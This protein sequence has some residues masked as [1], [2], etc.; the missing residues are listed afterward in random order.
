[1]AGQ[2]QQQMQQ[3]V[4]T[5][6]NRSSSSSSST[7][8]SAPS[9]RPEIA[10]IIPLFDLVQGH[11]PYDD[12]PEQLTSAL[13]DYFVAAA[14]KVKQSNCECCSSCGCDVAGRPPLL[15]PAFYRS[16]QEDLMQGVAV[17]HLA[18]E[19]SADVQ[20]RCRLAVVAVL[21][22]IT[23]AA[24]IDDVTQ[25]LLRYIGQQEL[26]IAARVAAHAGC[27]RII[28]QQRVI[29]Q[30]GKPLEQC[31]NEDLAQLLP[32]FRDTLTEVRKCMGSST[33]DE[34]AVTTDQA[35]ICSTAAALLRA[36]G[37]TAD[38]AAAPAAAAVATAAAVA[39]PTGDASAVPAAAAATAS[40]S[41]SGSSSSSGWRSLSALSGLFKGITSRKVSSA[42]GA[43]DAA[44]GPPG[45]GGRDAAARGSIYALAA[46]AGASGVGDAEPGGLQALASA[47]DSDAES[48]DDAFEQEVKQKFWSPASADY[49]KEQEATTGELDCICRLAL[50]ND[51]NNEGWNALHYAAAT[52]KLGANP[53]GAEGTFGLQPLHLAC[54]GRVKDAA[55][56]D[57][58][59]DACGDIYSLQ[60]YAVMAGPACRPLVQLLLSK[61]V[62]PTSAVDCLFDELAGITPLHLLACWRHATSAVLSGGPAALLRAVAAQHVGAVRDLLQA[63]GA[64]GDSADVA[65]RTTCCKE[66]PLTFAAF[67]GSW[68]V[69]ELLLQA[70]ASP[71]LPRL[72]DAARPLDLAVALLHTRLACLLL[73]RGVEVGMGRRRQCKQQQQQ[74]LGLACLLLERG[75]EVRAR[76]CGAAGRLAPAAGAKSMRAHVIPSEAQ[77]AWVGMAPQPTP[78]RMQSNM[79]LLKSVECSAAP[80]NARL[81]ELLLQHGV[82]LEEVNRRGETAL[83]SAVVRDNTE[84][85]AHSPLC[86]CLSLRTTADA[87]GCLQMVRLLVAAGAN[88]EAARQQ[89]TPRTPLAEAAANGQL[90]ICR[91]C[92]C[93]RACVWDVAC[94]W[95]A[96]AGA[97]HTSYK[98][99]HTGNGLVQLA[100]SAGQFEAVV[101]LVEAG[102]SWRLA[103]STD[104]AVDGAALYVPDILSSKLPGVKA[105]TIES[106]LYLAEEVAKQRKDKAAAAEARSKFSSKAPVSDGGAAGAVPKE[107]QQPAAALDDI[108]ALAAEIEALGGGGGGSSNPAASGSGGSK[109]SKKQEKL[110]KQRAKQQQ[111]QQRTTAQGSEQ[112]SEDEEEPA[113]SS[114][115]AADHLSKL[116]G[117]VSLEALQRIAGASSGAA[118]K[119]HATQRVQQLQR[120]ASQRRQQRGQE[121]QLEVQQQQQQQ[122]SMPVMELPEDVLAHASAL[123][124]QVSSRQQQQLR[125]QKKEARLQQRAAAHAAKSRAPPG[126]AVSSLAAAAQQAA[127]LQAAEQSSAGA[128]DAPAVPARP[129]AAA[130]A[131]ASE[132]AAAS[133]A[134]ACV[135][136]PAPAATGSAGSSRHAG[137]STAGPAAAAS[138]AS[139]EEAP[140]APSMLHSWRGSLNPMYMWGRLTSSGDSAP[141]PAA[142]AAAQRQAAGRQIYNP[143]QFQQQQQ[144]QQGR[145]TQRSGA[146]ADTSAAA[147]TA[148]SESAGN[149]KMQTQQKCI[150]CMERLRDVL[151]LPCKHLVLCSGCAEQLE[152]RGA[153][154]SCPYC[155][156]PCAQRV[157]VHQ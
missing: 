15:L 94:V 54:L 109:K 85:R 68:A 8:S 59:I 19:C 17:I 4:C 26:G 34:A 79:L 72:A 11:D 21:A 29:E 76:G 33:A 141:P 38:D 75:A 114:A 55:G 24:H 153:L 157:R 92:W 58:L 46:A 74:R 137:R 98:E 139:A 136:A 16:L 65:A 36:P 115:A 77:Q 37:V 152:G 50:H 40:S 121:Q 119:Q 35:M 53:C 9:T 143:Q 118:A 128:A 104:R 127:L 41:G 30:L 120:P 49:P 22:A 61:Q 123:L 60:K 151:L 144:Q 80:H 57:E 7:P 124:Q 140:P 47:D 125:Q 62:D 28:G 134:A 102:A 27:A 91:C 44:A 132:A 42:A 93:D 31:C 43:A 138:P 105:G 103:A 130:A 45:N 18:A 89:G 5:A 113:A 149:S 83:L 32:I 155:R 14:E 135:A 56:L 51:G 110:K 48:A 147:G 52:H 95:I 126:V 106:K 70:G 112:A 145:Q 39:A 142:A 25:Q 101:K 82:P 6:P 84:R 10:S 69:V 23:K 2:Q 146:A 133:P 117:D 88:L 148:A 111:K 87:L 12:M 13:K 78:A 150:V 63:R 116:L 64:D 154:G 73:E 67:S 131:A 71:D 129:A 156:Q 97:D 3:H 96:D 107:Q 81:A 100:A 108:D 20:G 86:D 66:T 90:E 99:K 1:M 122:T